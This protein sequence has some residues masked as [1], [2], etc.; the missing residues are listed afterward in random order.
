M[1]VALHHKTLNKNICGCQKW[2][3]QSWRVLWSL[4]NQRH[5]KIHALHRNSLTIEFYQINRI[6]FHI[7]R[8][9]CEKSD[10]TGWFGHVERPNSYARWFTICNTTYINASLIECS[11]L[12]VDTNEQDRSDLLDSSIFEH[13]LYARNKEKP[14]YLRQSATKLLGKSITGSFMLFTFLE[15]FAWTFSKRM[16]PREHWDGLH[17]GNTGEVSTISNIYE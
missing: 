9:S 2:L 15:L 6:H 14:S 7:A 5:S 16:I 11:H 3:H 12:P 17:L 1:A 10:T 4:P 13:L 8:M